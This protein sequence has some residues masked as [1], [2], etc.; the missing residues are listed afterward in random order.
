MGKFLFFVGQVIVIGLIIAGLIFLAGVVFQRN[1]IA[2]VDTSP[3]GVSVV[4]DANNTKTSGSLSLGDPQV[5][6]YADG[7]DSFGKVVPAG[8]EVKG[9]AFVKP[10]RDLDWG[11]PVYIGEE[12]TTQ[13]SDEVVWLLTGDNACVDAQGMFFTYWSKNSPT[14]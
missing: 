14:K 9:P 13:A 12:Y 7:F 2:C 1:A 6:K 8:T 5:C 4:K 11:H 10:D 3:V